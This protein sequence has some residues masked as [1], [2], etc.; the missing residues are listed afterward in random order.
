MISLKR[1]DSF[2]GVVTV[3][4]GG[5]LS[6]KAAS[7]ALKRWRQ[8]LSLAWRRHHRRKQQLA[9]IPL[10]QISHGALALLNIGEAGAAAAHGGNAIALRIAGCRCQPASAT[11]AAGIWLASACVGNRLS[12]QK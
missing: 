12:R 6:A 5:G 11:A 2:T 4:D 9:A 3:I 1:N 8:P 7:S 10:H